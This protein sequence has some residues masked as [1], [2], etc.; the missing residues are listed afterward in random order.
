MRERRERRE[1]REKIGLVYIFK[2]I[3]HLYMYPLFPK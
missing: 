2:E 3:Y 1:K